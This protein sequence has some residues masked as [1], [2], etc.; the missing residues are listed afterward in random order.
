MAKSKLTIDDLKGDLLKL[1]DKV[2]ALEQKI[3]NL[4]WKVNLKCNDMQ[5]KIDKVELD[6]EFKLK[7]RSE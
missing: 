5:K 4:N 1:I 2:E 7:Q 3:I 6:Y